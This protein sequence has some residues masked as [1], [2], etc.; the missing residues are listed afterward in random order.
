[1]SNVVDGLILDCEFVY[2][3]DKKTSQM[4]KTHP[5]CSKIKIDSSNV[6]VET[7]VSDL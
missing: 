3:C 2:L 1:M 6:E 5:M 7:Q 4:I